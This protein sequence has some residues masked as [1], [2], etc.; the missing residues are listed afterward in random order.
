MPEQNGLDRTPATMSACLLRQ[1]RA[2]VVYRV[3]RGMQPRRC[4]CSSASQRAPCL[5]PLNPGML[6]QLC[7]CGF[8]FFCAQ[9]RR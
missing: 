4:R 9:A 6:L 7:I 1:A 2:A 3:P 8:Y 5:H